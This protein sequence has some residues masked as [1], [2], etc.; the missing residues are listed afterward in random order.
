MTAPRIVVDTESGV[1]PWRQVRDQIA[2]LAGGGALPVG[3]RLP[4]IR[5]LARDLGLAAGT[6]ARAYRELESV[7][8]IRTARRLGTVVAEPPPGQAGPPDRRAAELRQAAANY[9]TTA[10]ALG[11][12]VEAAVLAVRAEFAGPNHVR[13]Q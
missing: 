2:A 12:D 13:P 3:A 11:A 10:R 6:V 7:G 5:Q 1:A 4:P 8:V 9:A